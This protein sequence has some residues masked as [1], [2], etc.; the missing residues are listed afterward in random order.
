MA[1]AWFQ[2]PFGNILSII[3]NEEAS[4]GQRADDRQMASASR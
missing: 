1:V 3:E 4:T 2:D